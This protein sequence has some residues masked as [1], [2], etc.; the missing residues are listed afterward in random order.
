MKPKEVIDVVVQWTRIGICAVACLFPGFA[1]GANDVLVRGQGV[2]VT[3]ADILLDAE[4]LPEELR[5]S[6]LGNPA[7]IE[8]IAMNL[9]VRRV[10]A[11][12]AR[13]AGLTNDPKVKVAEELAMDKLLSDAFLAK[14]VAA[15]QPPSEEALE[16]LARGVY[17]ADD[18]GFATPEER[19]VRHI[20]IGHKTENARAR[21]D[22]V[23]EKLRNG[24]DFAALAKEYSEDPGSR[25]KGGDLGSFGRG[26]M[27]KPF[28]DAAFGLASPGDIAGP[29]ETQFGF[30]VLRL[31]EIR[32]PGRK[33][34]EEFSAEI[35]RGI[36]SKISAD[37]RVE[38]L[39]PIQEGGFDIDKKA[40]E[41]FAQQKH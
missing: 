26:R 11:K 17:A 4:R 1:L 14:A 12:Q 9:F 29:V 36:R 8:Q 39:R 38:I 32:P 18:G 28:E 40:M 37:R 16:A 7:R 2:V 3:T 22:E 23:L 27:V 41:S 19:R 30:H 25:E 13:E 20:L 24:A 31:E 21:A 35:K 15:A 33:P 5:A 10:L 34:Y 6:I